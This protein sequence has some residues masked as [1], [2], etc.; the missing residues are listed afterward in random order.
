VASEVEVI[1]YKVRTTRLFEEAVERV[2]EGVIE[3]ENEEVIK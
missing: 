1:G 3:D 2:V